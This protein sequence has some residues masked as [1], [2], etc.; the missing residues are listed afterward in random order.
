MSAIDGLQVYQRIGRN[1]VLVDLLGLI[2]PGQ[3]AVFLLRPSY[4][5]LS[6]SLMAYRAANRKSFE[7]NEELP[8]QLLSGTSL[9][10]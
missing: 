6:R 7:G 10:I 5:V 2:H 1:L 3:A 4:L 9:P 8:A